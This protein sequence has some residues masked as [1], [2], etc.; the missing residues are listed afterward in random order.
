MLPKPEGIE[1][2]LLGPFGHGQNFL[3]IFLIRTTDVRGVVAENEYAEL[4][5]RGSFLSLTS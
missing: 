3:V 5:E 1:S 2:Q 4:H